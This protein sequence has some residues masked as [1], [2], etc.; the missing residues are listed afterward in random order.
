[1][2]LRIELRGFF[3]TKHRYHAMHYLSLVLAIEQYLVLSFLLLKL[4]SIKTIQSCRINE[5]YHKSRNFSKSKIK[6]FIL[7]ILILA[8]CNLAIFNNYIKNYIMSKRDVLLLAIYNF[9]KLKSLADNGKI[10]SSLKF[11]L[12]Q[13][14]YPTL[15]SVIYK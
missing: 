6:R 3:L 4:K 7:I 1:M 14:M 12:V 5:I 8:I 15:C 11:L 9:S 2:M 13:Y 10:R